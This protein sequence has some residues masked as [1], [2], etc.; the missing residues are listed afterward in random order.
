MILGSPHTFVADCQPHERHK[1]HKLTFGDDICP[2]CVRP[3][4]ESS[5]MAIVVPIEIDPVFELVD[6]ITPDIILFSVSLQSDR[7]GEVLTYRILGG[8]S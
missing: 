2:G 4:K 1:R 7:G 6:I 8:V 5:D 3:I